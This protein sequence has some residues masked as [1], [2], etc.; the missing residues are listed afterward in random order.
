MSRMI[1]AAENMLADLMP[2]EL[3]LGLKTLAARLQADN[4]RLTAAFPVALEVEAPVSRI[5]SAQV[6]DVVLRAVLIE[7]TARLATSL[8]SD[9]TTLCPCSKAVSDYG[10]HNQRSRVTVEVSGVGE[11]LYPTTI[12]EL[13]AIIRSVGS[14]PVVPV[15]KRP[16]E[17]HL[18]M[19]AFDRP[20]F[21]E[22][23]VRELSAA[24]RAR[25]LSHRVQ[26]VNV[27]S[28]HSH[29]AVASL[30]WTG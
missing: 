11:N 28:I 16:D 9:I 5:V 30:S 24:L 22:D 2:Q 14:A 20:A 12:A 15:I 7:G 8:T 21:V 6:S 18:T 23:V 17:R 3:G 26:S 4:V 13:F 19:Q 29:D 25:Q 27:E 1:Q 10:A